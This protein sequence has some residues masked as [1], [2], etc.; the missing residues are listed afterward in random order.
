MIDIIKGLW[1]WIVWILVLLLIGAII[2]ALRI[3][4]IDK[5][6]DGKA[7]VASRENK[8][9]SATG[10]TDS[11]K[12]KKGGTDTSKK[13][14]SKEEENSQE[15]SDGLSEENDNDR[16]K[17]IGEAITS[18]YQKDS[19]YDY[20]PYEVDMRFLMFEGEQY[21]G[22]IRNILDL[23][24]SN[25][26]GNF[27]D[28]TAVT[29]VGFGENQTITYKGNLEEYRNQIRSLKSAVGNGTYDVS[30]RYGGLGTYINEIVITKK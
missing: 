27:Y 15:A 25:S 5:D 28:R 19:E 18:G 10:K 22:A 14:N 1:K 2:L 20:N 24:I 21:E 4:V 29:A 12:S 8:I 7:R 30:F 23:L 17:T 16:E 11:M 26:E 13:T 3:F 9:T 6:Y